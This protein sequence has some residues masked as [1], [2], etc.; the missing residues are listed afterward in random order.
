MI[1]YVNFLMNIKRTKEKL[2]MD[3][4]EVALLFIKIYRLYDTHKI[5]YY[6]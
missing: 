5:I 2:N 6:S 1:K 4:G 3:Y